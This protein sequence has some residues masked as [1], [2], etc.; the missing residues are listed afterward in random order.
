ML[1]GLSRSPMFPPLAA[2]GETEL[3]ERLDERLRSE[4]KLVGTRTRS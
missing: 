3:D 2:C 4:V 1:E